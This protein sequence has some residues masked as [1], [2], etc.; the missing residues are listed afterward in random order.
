M[1]LTDDDEPEYRDLHRRLLE[2]P[3]GIEG[4]VSFDELTAEYTPR[5]DPTSRIGEKVGDYQLVEVL[6]SGAN[7]SVYRARHEKLD[8]DFAIKVLAPTGANI[9]RSLERFHSE[10]KAIGRLDH[11]NIVRATNASESNGEH[12]LVME[13]VDG[14]D[15]ST[16]VRRQSPL[17]VA[18]AVEIAVQAARGLAVAHAQRMVHRDVKPSNLLF[19]YDGVVRVLDLGL[20]S[21]A[22]DNDA[23]FTAL[24]RGTADYMAPEQWDNYDAVDDKADIYSLGCTLYKLLLGNAPFVPVPGEFKSKMEAHQF[25]PIPSLRVRRP[26]VPMGLDRVV[27][28]MLNKNPANRYE[29]MEAA[30]RAMEPYADGANLPRLAQ[31]LLGREVEEPPTPVVKAKLLSRRNVLSGTAILL[32]AAYSGR[33]FFSFGA[34]EPVLQFDNWRPMVST[35]PNRILESQQVEQPLLVDPKNVEYTISVPGLAIYPMGQPVRDRFAM[36]AFVTMSDPPSLPGVAPPSKS[37]LFYAY[38]PEMLEVGRRHPLRSV[39]L[40]RSDDRLS[41]VWADVTWDETPK[42]SGIKSEP[43][44]KVR[45]EAGGKQTKLFVEI[46]TSPLPV[47]KVDEKAVTDQQWVTTAA[48]AHAVRIAENEILVN[49]GQVGLF[50]ECSTACFAEPRLKYVK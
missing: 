13:F 37:G 4:T 28:N 5:I 10:L 45:I 27:R 16:L 12:F 24:A 36:E 8:R 34:K 9:D 49:Q 17:A 46:G 44:A 32:A 2:T 3:E 43:L 40:E 23:A 39:Y 48:G 50:V 29:N 38:R 35:K 18:D 25:A 30:I 1:S 11:P 47:V 7:G 33:S 6:G 21:I 14:I 22:D 15:A 26:D 42:N 31:R 19:G 20:V 41:L